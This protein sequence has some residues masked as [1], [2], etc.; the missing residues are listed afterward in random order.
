MQFQTE[1]LDT[2]MHVVE[3]LLQAHWDEVEASVHGAQEYM[4]DKEQYRLFESLNLLHISTARDE[5]HDLCG[6]AVFTLTPCHHKK[7]ELLATLD[8]LY[9]R[10]KARTGFAALQLLRAAEEALIQ[11]G[12]KSVQYSSPVSKPCDALYRRLGAKHTESV[13]HKIL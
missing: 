12:A 4:L 7:S 8:A 3:E 13:Y 9:L 11:R 1:C 2:V 5:H 10:P 6:Y